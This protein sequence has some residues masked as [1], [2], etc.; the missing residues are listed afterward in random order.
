MEMIY[1]VMGE[2]SSMINVMGMISSGWGETTI[3]ISENF[4]W[5]GETHHY[6]P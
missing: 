5:V 2:R 3:I 6:H 1:S 4:H